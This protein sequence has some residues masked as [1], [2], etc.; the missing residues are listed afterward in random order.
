MGSGPLQ[1]FLPEIAFAG[2]LEAHHVVHGNHRCVHNGIP[3]DDDTDAGCVPCQ[4]VEIGEFD[5]QPE[6]VA[7]VVGV[8]PRS[9]S[10]RPALVLRRRSRVRCTPPAGRRRRAAQPRSG[11][12]RR[13]RHAA[14][15]SP[16]PARR[17]RS[18][19][20]GL[21]RRGARRS[22]CTGRGVHW[23]WR[24]VAGH[25]ASN[26]RSAVRLGMARSCDLGAQLVHACAGD[27]HAEVAGIAGQHGCEA[28]LRRER[29]RGMVGG[30]VEWHV[31]N[32]V[33]HD[34]AVGPSVLGHAFDH[35]RPHAAAPLGRVN[36]HRDVRAAPVVAQRQLHHPHAENRAA[37]LARR[38][39][40]ETAWTDRRAGRRHGCPAARS[41]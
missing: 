27:R 23:S 33:E 16:V 29:Q 5:R 25:G 35:G 17:P 40:S 41:R 6:A 26:V 28:E 34:T 30:T 20:R 39:E 36:R 21:G 18:P 32:G 37:G 1:V 19:S 22:T 24:Y 3:G 31:H 38:Q 8:A 13:E 9:A 10:A 11:S 12:G 15:R 2:H 14:R 4:G 7:P